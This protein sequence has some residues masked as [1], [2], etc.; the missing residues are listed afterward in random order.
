MTAWS[1][2][3]INTFKQCPKKY[4]HLKIL[5]DVKDVGN[6][7]TFYGNAVHKAA[8]KY[9]KQGEPIPT[10]FD[11]I[12]KPLEA[13]NRIKG[14]KLCELRM[15]IAK[16]GN[17]YS[18]TRYHSADAWWRGIA[19]LVIVN[20]EKAYIVDYKTGKNTAYAD[21]KQ[22]DMLA[23]ATFVCYP[24]V[25]V[26]KSALAYVVSND[27]IKKQHTVDMY[28]SY[29]SVFDEALEQLAVAKEKNVWNAIDG[30]LCAYCPVTS[31][32]HNRKQ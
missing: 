23:G 19:D 11:Y 26:I 29:L 27:F 10:K 3:S 4:Y 31:C 1:Y 7:A 2:S 21:T 28:K 17:T 30:P 9:I 12:K 24:Y 5:K 20:D 8:E 16:K 15:A 18:P 22:L 6:S 13:L 32:E 14:Q 25:K